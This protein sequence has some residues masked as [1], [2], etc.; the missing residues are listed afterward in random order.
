M[1]TTFGLEVLISQLLG[2]W[3]V[4]APSCIILGELLFE[5]GCLAHPLPCVQL[6]SSRL[7]KAGRVTRPGSFAS[8]WENLHSCITVQLLLLLHSL[9]WI[10]RSILRAFRNKTDTKYPSQNP[11]FRKPNLS[12]KRL[13]KVHIHK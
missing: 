3:V 8:V 13:T 10:L 4:G 5:G 1:S 2:D 6:T 9:P 11:F 12:H 7:V